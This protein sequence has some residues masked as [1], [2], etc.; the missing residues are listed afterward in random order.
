[1][2]QVEPDVHKSGR[3]IL[4]TQPLMVISRLRRVPPVVNHPQ[5]GNKMSYER[6]N[7]VNI[8]RQTADDKTTKNNNLTN[9]VA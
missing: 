9:Y 5:D 4:P 6:R 3:R 2:D 7:E 8:Y 1:M